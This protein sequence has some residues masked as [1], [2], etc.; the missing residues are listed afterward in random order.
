MSFYE[1]YC[2]K[3]FDLLNNRSECAIL[4]DSQEIVNIKN[5][6]ELTIQNTENIMDLINFGLD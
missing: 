6:M 1:I 4:V 5:L 3:A 2:D